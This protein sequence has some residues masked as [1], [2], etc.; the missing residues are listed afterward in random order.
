MTIHTANEY[1]RSFFT[2]VP[3]D[4]VSLDQIFASE[5]RDLG[6]EV[7]NKMWL[8]NKLTPMRRY[9]LVTPIYKKRRLVGLRLSKDGKIV[10]GRG[11]DITTNVSMP[12]NGTKN[13]N[14]PMSLEDILSGIAK[15]KRENPDLKVTFSITS[16]EDDGGRSGIDTG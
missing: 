10:L 12:L 6:H 11:I 4:V 1:L 13:K 14:G 2:N 9:H 15:F 3:G 8:G 16:K 5:G 7:R